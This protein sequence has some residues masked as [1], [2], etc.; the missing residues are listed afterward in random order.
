M[1]MVKRRVKTEKPKMGM[2][3]IPN[4]HWKH[5]MWLI[6]G[7]EPPRPRDTTLP[8]W[9]DI[10]AEI[11]R[12]KHG[13]DK[14]ELG[15]QIGSILH[16]VFIFPVKFAYRIVCGLAWLGYIMLTNLVRVATYAW[17]IFFFGG[18]VYFWLKIK[19]AQ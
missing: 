13:D 8:R 17:L 16:Y 19:G 9:L 1:S 10:D 11:A 4:L 18:I 5:G 3:G 14:E 2:G 12:R 7:Q 6:E 15:R